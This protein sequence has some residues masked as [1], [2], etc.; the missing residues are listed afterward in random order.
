MPLNAYV[1][2][3]PANAP[4]AVT[5]YFGDDGIEM[6]DAR[7]QVE[8]IA[9]PWLKIHD[10]RGS[11]IV[12]GRKWISGFRLH[13]SGES[14]QIAREKLA[15]TPWLRR[16]GRWALGS[17]KAAL[18]LLALPYIMV[19]SLPN[20]WLARATPPALSRGIEATAIGE[21]ARH[22][23]S[24]PTGNAA[25]QSLI[26][27]VA[28]ETDA[29]KAMVIDQP[30]F[31]VSARP[32]GELLIYRSATTEVESEVLAAMVAHALAHQ[33]A[34]HDR[35]A[36]GRGVD[37]YLSRLTVLRFDRDLV[38]LAYSPEEETAADRAAIAMLRRAGISL[39]PAADFFARVNKAE[40]TARYWAQEYAEEHP[41][42][43]NRAA[44]WAAAASAQ[45]GTHVALTEQQSD[46]LF[47]ICWKRPSY[48]RPKWE[49]ARN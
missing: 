11:S 7:G 40:L 34:G 26:S 46:A 15:P 45:T 8:H 17:P 41:G 30:S 24:D 12:V 49:I 23:C 44:V 32:G 14:A 10:D 29:S 19:D 47:N 4:R 39:R 20:M 6:S 16:A 48:V 9:Y 31:I 3:G 38:R 43:S 25:L 35:M 33:Q 13:L 5:I 27:A 37:D 2:R 42:M 21:V 18:F 22:S 36:V 1:T 28:P